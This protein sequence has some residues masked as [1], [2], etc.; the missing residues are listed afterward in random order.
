M[1]RCF[2]QRL[3]G[4]TAIAVLGL[5]AFAPSGH[6]EQPPFRPIGIFVDLHRRDFRKEP[7]EHWTRLLQGLQG[8]GFDTV[9][10]RVDA[11]M[12]CRAQTLDMK[13]ITAAAWD[14]PDRT[15]AWEAYPSLL[16]WIGTDEPGR[17]NQIDLA[18]SQYAAFR[19]IASRPLAVSIYLPEAY[20]HANDLADILLPDPYIFGHVRRDG[21]FY[22]IDEIP[23]RIGA[24]RTRL[25]PEKRIWAVPQLYAWHPHFK[26]P[27][28]PD[29]LE[30]QTILCLGEGAEGI[31]YF[32]LNSGDYYPHPPDYNPRSA[33]EQP[34]A[35]DLYRHPDLLERVRKVNRIARYILSQY[36]GP[37]EKESLQGGGVRYT[38]RRESA[39]FSAE[40]HLTPGISLNYSF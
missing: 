35:W 34:A 30:A 19:Q 29:E 1:N 4:L 20:D 25:H 26:R 7:I 36:D 18:K 28:T 40:V 31:L 39:R 15:R 33:D 2:T 22:P 8:L 9:V 23:L 3:A 32:S 6:A 24:L 17:T 13:V 5:C 11:P 10:A 12:L 21:S 27:P 14:R 16:A 38:W 37:A